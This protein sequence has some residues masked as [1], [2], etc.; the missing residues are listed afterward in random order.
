M[1][2]SVSIAADGYSLAVSALNRNGDGFDEGQTR[3]YKWENN[4]W[5]QLGENINGENDFD[6]SGRSVALSGNGD[7]VAIGASDNDDSFPTAGHV[8]VY[9]LTE[10]TNTEILSIRSLKL[11]PNPTNGILNLESDYNLDF[12]E[13]TDLSGRSLFQ[14]SEVDDQM[15]ISKLE[16]GI[17]FIKINIESDIL[18]RKIIKE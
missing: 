4:S 15:D 11:F 1:G 14:S 18:V 8:R 5:L 16:Y 12:V 6:R 17:Y 13:V 10:L 9:E 3:I 2:Y 7:F